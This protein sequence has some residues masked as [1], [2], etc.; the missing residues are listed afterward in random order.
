MVP[1]DRDRDQD[2]QEELALKSSLLTLKASFLNSEA[3]ES[4]LVLVNH[5]FSSYFL[6]INPCLDQEMVVALFLLSLTLV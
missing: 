5:P 3:D 6:S 1:L 4:C 2:H